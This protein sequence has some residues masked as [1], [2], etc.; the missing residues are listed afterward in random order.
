M[1]PEKGG[2]GITALILAS[3]YGHTEIVAMLPEKGDDV[4]V[5]DNDGWT[6]LIVASFYGH[7]E[8]VAMLPEKGADVNAKNNDGYTALI[9]ASVRGHEEIVINLLTN[10]ADVNAKDHNDYTALL[11]AVKFG[12]TS[13]V[14]LLE[15]AIETEKKIIGHKQ[16]AMKLVRHRD[17]KI[18]SLRTLAYRQLP[19]YTTTEI[20]QYDLLPPSK[21]GGKRK[22][23]KTHIK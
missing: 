20:N 10:G 3:R 19:T 8:I 9:M 2:D 1:L 23:R 22:T 11:W 15:K 14:D 12:H 6:A 4:N 21:L 18:P 5:K 7:T 16:A 13:I 17:V